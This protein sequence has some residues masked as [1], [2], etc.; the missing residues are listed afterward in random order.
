MAAQDRHQVVVGVDGSAGSRNALRWAGRLARLLDDEVTAVHGAGLLEHVGQGFVLTHPHIAGLREVVEREWCGSLAQSGVAHRVQV[1]E[2]PAVD[3]LLAAAAERRTDLVV[4][5]TRGVGLAADQ[6]LGSTALQ[7]LA[8]AD[9]PVLVVPDRQDVPSVEV[10]RV[11]V[12]FDGSPDASAA[13]DWAVDIAGRVG[14][15]CEVAIAADDAAPARLQAV[16]EDAC[17]P[18]HRKGLPYRVTV[19]RGEP[20]PTIEG[21]AAAGQADLLVLGSSGEGLD[22]DPLAGSVSRMV[23]HHA[24]RPVVVVPGSRASRPFAPGSHGRQAARA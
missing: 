19:R 5:G 15:A 22:G 11:T 6:A 23:A 7:L 4:V 21:I 16:V 9:V 12:G 1:V 3:A 2:R 24:G 18:L 20:A 10:R 8:R 13:L 17:R 14:A